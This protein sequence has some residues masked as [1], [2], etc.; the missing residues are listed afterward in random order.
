MTWTWAQFTS[1][2][3]ARANLKTNQIKSNRYHARSNEFVQ[4]HFTCGLNPAR[5]IIP[6]TFIYFHYDT[7]SQRQFEFQL[8]ASFV[9]KPFSLCNT[10]RKW[11]SKVATV[12][13]RQSSKVESSVA[14][15]LILTTALTY[16]LTK[17]AA[18]SKSRQTF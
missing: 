5:D 8:F 11:R 13:W 12:L 17:K 10:W 3:S 2:Y 4:I 1:Q 18:Y 6:A 16:L 15:A 9:S 14:S 7:Q